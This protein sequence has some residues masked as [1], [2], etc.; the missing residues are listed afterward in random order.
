MQHEQAQVRGTLGGPRTSLQEGDTFDIVSFVLT[1]LCSSLILRNHPFDF[2]KISLFM[3]QFDPPFAEE[4]MSTIISPRSDGMQ[5]VSKNMFND[6]EENSS[7]L[8]SDDDRLEGWKPPAAS[9]MDNS[10]ALST[11]EDISSGNVRLE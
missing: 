5:N 3:L 8:D 7:S 4:W 6:D 11:F 10:K 1:D 2:T 9:G